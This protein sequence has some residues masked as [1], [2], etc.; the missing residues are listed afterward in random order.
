V[1]ELVRA[2]WISQLCGDLSTGAGG[3]LHHQ[4]SDP[5]AGSEHEHAAPEPRPG[6]PHRA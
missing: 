4:V 2:R 6:E 1:D 3:E 5:A